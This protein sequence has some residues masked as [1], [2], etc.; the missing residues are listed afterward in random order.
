MQ[1]ARAFDSGFVKVELRSRSPKLWGW[2]LYCE[3]SERMLDRS[4]GA[5]RYA[6]DAWKAGQVALAAVESH[7]RSPVEAMR[8]AA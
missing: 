6:E 2:T 1:S 3:V 7:S 5:Y 8:Q 4:A